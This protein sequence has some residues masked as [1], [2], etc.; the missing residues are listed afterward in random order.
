MNNPFEELGTV[1]SSYNQLPSDLNLL[2]LKA[3]IKRSYLLIEADVFIFIYIKR[4]NN[5]DRFQKAEITISNGLNIKLV[6]LNKINNMKK[7]EK[8]ELF[9]KKFK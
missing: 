9:I 6:K 7:R 4:Q 3:E 1:E 2:N 8:L 5:I